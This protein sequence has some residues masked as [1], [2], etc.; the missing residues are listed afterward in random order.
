LI[1]DASSN[2]GVQSAGDDVTPVK[3]RRNRSAAIADQ[4]QHP[5]I[6]ATTLESNFDEKVDGAPVQFENPLTSTNAARKVTPRATVAEP[7]AKKFVHR[8]ILVD[9]I[10]NLFLSF[11][12]CERG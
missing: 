5:F 1:L 3:D 6:T 2:A 8:V 7:P 4:A 9:G 11:S 10:Q 12:L